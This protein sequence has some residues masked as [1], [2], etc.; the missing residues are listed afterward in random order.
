M[1]AKEI[2]NWFIVVFWMYGLS[3][4]RAVFVYAFVLFF[5]RT[6]S[7]KVYS[8]MELFEF[9][10]RASFL[11]LLACYFS[12]K[13]IPWNCYG[14]IAFCFCSRFFLLLFAFHFLIMNVNEYAFLLSRLYLFAHFH[15]SLFSF[16]DKLK[17]LVRKLKRM[18]RKWLGSS[19]EW[20]GNG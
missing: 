9:E 3:G 7:E 2:E 10:V 16:Y 4:E 20:L 1:Q 18:V 8:R 11:D 5:I 15:P 6:T 14:F 12:L 13:T 19:K 17:R